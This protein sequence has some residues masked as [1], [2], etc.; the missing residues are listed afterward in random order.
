MQHAAVFSNFNDAKHF[1]I[2]RG[3]ASVDATPLVDVNTR[4]L[5]S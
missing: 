3:R 5:L 2:V 1:Y 4:N